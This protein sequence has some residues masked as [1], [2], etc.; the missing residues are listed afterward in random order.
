MLTIL[1]LGGA[2]D[3]PLQGNYQSVKSGLPALISNLILL[4]ITIGGLLVLLN[5]IIAGYDYMTASGDPKKIQNAWGKIYY[6][7]LGLIIIVAS[8]AF[9]SIISDVFNLS[10][11]KPSISGPGTL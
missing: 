6:S 1:Q 10:I 8:L 9:I 2:I 11:L 3:S 4:A 7:L 5:F